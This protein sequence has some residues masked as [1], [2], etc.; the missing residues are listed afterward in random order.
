MAGFLSF[1]DVMLNEMSLAD[2]ACFKYT[3]SRI[4]VA[5][6]HWVSYIFFFIPQTIFLFLFYPI[7]LVFLKWFFNFRLLII[8]SEVLKFVTDLLGFPGLLMLEYY[9][10]GRGNPED[11]LLR[12]W[13]NP[14]VPYI[15]VC[16]YRK[17]KGI[18]DDP[19]FPVT[20]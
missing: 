12:M 6:K 17:E 18:K 1:C 7:N 9:R 10:K 19:P 2:E 14:F 16:N 15:I 4:K 8:F 11:V 5:I 20:E 13:K 3:G